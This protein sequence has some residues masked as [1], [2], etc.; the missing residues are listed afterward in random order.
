M[1]LG[2]FF[3]GHPLD[4]WRDLIDRTVNVDLSRKDTLTND[5]ACTLIG[6][7]SDVREI[8]TRNGRTM[9][10]AQLEDHRGSIE[11]IL[12]SDVYESRRAADRQ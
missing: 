1:N 3:S 12:F 5:R 6:I 2:F 9:A 10:F 8:R 11:L 7:L 4:P